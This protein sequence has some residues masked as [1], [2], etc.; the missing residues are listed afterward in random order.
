MLLSLN[1]ALRQM[2]TIPTKHTIQLARYSSRN[3]LLRDIIHV[4]RDVRITN[5]QSYATNALNSNEFNTYVIN[6]DTKKD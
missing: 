2:S 5:M 4:L 1:L 6:S 3:G